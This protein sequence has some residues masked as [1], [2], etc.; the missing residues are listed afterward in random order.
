MELII[1][2]Q[3][4]SLSEGF[5]ST[6]NHPVAVA[7][8]QNNPEMENVQVQHNRLTA[9]REGYPVRFLITHYT[10]K[11]HRRLL[12]G[13]VTTIPCTLEPLAVVPANN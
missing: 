6:T 7:F 1:T 8:R 2:T 4:V 9:T 13:H 12:L 11:D 5:M 10:V 3:H